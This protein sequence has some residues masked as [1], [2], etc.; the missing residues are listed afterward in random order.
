MRCMAMWAWDAGA[1]GRGGMLCWR[2][3]AVFKAA[4]CCFGVLRLCVGV[5]VMVGVCVGGLVRSCG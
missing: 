1:W 5:R 4:K 3:Q 2:L